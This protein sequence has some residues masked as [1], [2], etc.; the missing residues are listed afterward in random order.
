MKPFKEL[1]RWTT[2]AGL[3]AYTVIYE[4]GN[5]NGYVIVPPTNKYANKHY[6]DIENIDVHGGLTYSKVINGNTVFGFD[7]AHLGDALN[8][9][10]AFDHLSEPN[11]N[12]KKLRKLFAM[13]YIDS[14]DTWKDEAYVEAE[15]EK[16][17]QQLKD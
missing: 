10:F 12:K 2:E 17:A 15:C 6:F 1:K 16:L 9:D 4:T 11:D 8:F 3:V 5:I 7:T 14:S 13:P